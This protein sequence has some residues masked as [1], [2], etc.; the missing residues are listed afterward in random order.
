MVDDD[1]GEDERWSGVLL[2]DRDRRQR[3][4]AD[5]RAAEPTWLEAVTAPRLSTPLPASLP[6]LRL[7]ANAAYL[8]R[9]TI[10]PS[11]T[12]GALRDLQ[13]DDCRSAVDRLFAAGLRQGRRG[14]QGFSALYGLPTTQGSYRARSR[15]RGHFPGASHM[16]KSSISV[17]STSRRL[18][19]HRRDVARAAER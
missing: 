11:R 18:P 9:T 8:R 7:D 13:Q 1:D 17:A 14:R 4:A 12:T 16:V 5:S 2:R 3:G 10:W 19:C 15:R 6:L